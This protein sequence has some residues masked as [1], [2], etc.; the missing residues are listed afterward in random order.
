[1]I[2][3][4]GGRVEI[5]TIPSAGFVSLFGSTILWLALIYLAIALLM[6]NR[7]M[8]VIRSLFR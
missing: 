5:Q 8:G 1:M 4:A 3:C 7:E 2:A 6:K